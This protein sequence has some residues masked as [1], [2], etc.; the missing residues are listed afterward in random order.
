MLQATVA[1]RLPITRTA[2]VYCLRENV[3]IQRI[4]PKDW[5]IFAREP[6][7]LTYKCGADVI[8]EPIHGTYTLSTDQDCEVFLENVKLLH[9]RYYAGELGYRA[10]PIITLPKPKHNDLINPV[11]VNL[12]GVPLDDLKQLSSELKRNTPFSESAESGTVK[13]K[14]VSLT[15]ILLC[16]ILALILIIISVRKIRTLICD[17]QRNYQSV[18]HQDNFALREGGVMSP[19]P[20][21][22]QVRAG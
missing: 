22:I 4:S 8:K 14:S 10:T 15:T 1:E 17:R 13:V 3:K 16:I 21:V 19:Q 12:Q 6:K 11:T 20:S 7:V 2:D 18:E 9:Q 5:I